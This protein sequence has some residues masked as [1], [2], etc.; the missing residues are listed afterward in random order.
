MN[1][2]TGEKYA[3]VTG[4]TGLL[5]SHLIKQL[6]EKG[7]NIKALYRSEA[8]RTSAGINNVLVEWVQGDIL[9][10]PSLED[11]MINVDEVY[12][13]AALVSFSPKRKK[14]LNKINVEGTANVVN[15]CINAGVRKLVHVSSVAALG[16]IREDVPID[17]TMNW[18]EE[19]SNS[20]YGRTKYLAEMEVWRGIAEGL[21]AVMVN[22]VIIL[23]AG[24][25]EKGS[26]EIFKSVYDEFPWYA[27]GVTGFVD[28]QD[29]ARAMIMLMESDLTAQRYIL[30]AANKSYKEIFDLIAE[31]FKKKKASKRVTPFIAALVWRWEALKSIITGKPPM[32]TKETAATALAHVYFDNSKLLK[33]LPA[34]TYTPIEKSV[35]RICGELMRKFVLV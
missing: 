5:G 7:K 27:D 12:H 26:S 21:D 28:A 1:N 8:S 32:V 11:A 22:P 29:V 35:E 6:I 17:E 16:R 13:C 19:T 30:S 25:W 20:E 9:D 14:D 18:T 10:I 33:A 23:G 34:F 3:L 15:A 4:A 24:D 31:N 2:S